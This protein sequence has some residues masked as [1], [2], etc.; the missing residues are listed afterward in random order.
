MATECGVC[1]EKYNKSYRAK[2]CCPYCDQEACRECFSKWIT[3]E[4]T[5]RCMNITCNKEWTRQF[6][7][8]AFTRVFLNNEYKKHKEQLLFE[9]EQALL[10]ATQP[11]VENILKCEKLSDQ[12]GTLEQEVSA[13]YARMASLRGEKYR[14][15]RGI[16]ARTPVEERATFIKACPDQNCR[17]FLSSQ[18][19]CG[20]C[21]QWTCPECHE[22]K[23][24][25]RDAAHICNPD[26]VE[27]AKLL[28][29][30]T[31][32]CPS[33]GTGIHKLEGCDQMFCT[34]CHT[35]FSWK[36]G[37]IET[38]IHNPHYYEWLRRTGGVAD[39]VHGEVI[40]GREITHTFARNL[41][42][43]LRQ[44]ANA[45]FDLVRRVSEICE[46]AIHLRMVTY[47]RY[48]VDHMLNNQDLR[49]AY[50]RNRISKDEL[51][52]RLQRED[53]KHQ[54]TREI[55]NVL[56]MLI[57]T[58]ADIMFRFQDA[59]QGDVRVPIPVNTI[60]DPMRDPIRIHTESVR[61]KENL[62]I[63]NEIDEIVKYSNECFEDISKTF[64]SKRLRINNNLRL[65]RA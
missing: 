62:D 15:E 7:T 30:D 54:K 37:K 9:Q 63:L 31:K 38:N 32:S 23:G 35:G 24:D 13:I 4:S 49:I 8:T 36:T 42:A 34:L 21:E 17:G 5:P 3:T 43:R 55:S 33:C 48:R 28:A 50:L 27:T 56:T 58:T 64:A 60:R 52:T 65:V 45:P 53:K 18:W 2:I 57:N 14:L 39:R 12:I 6:M 20:I 10:P 40:C 59:V 1:V 25:S 11:I 22:I 61:T 47:D 44:D 16:N 46:S 19:K 29:N 26:N 51:K 41:V